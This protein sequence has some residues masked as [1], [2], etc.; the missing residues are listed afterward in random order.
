M[1][2]KWRG[3]AF[4]PIL[5]EQ[6][7]RCIGIFPVGAVVELNSGEVAV[8]IAQ[9]LENASAADHGGARCCGKSASTAKTSGS[10]ES[11]E[12]ERRGLP[13]STHAEF[14][15]GNVSRADLFL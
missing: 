12:G 15:K 1:P 5:V 4:H 9:N 13:D 14:G 7:I 2:H 11:A 6:F 3:T 8:V 10:I